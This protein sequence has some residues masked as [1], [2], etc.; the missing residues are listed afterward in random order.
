MPNKITPDLAIVTGGCD[1]TVIENLLTGCPYL[2]TLEMIPLRSEPVAQALHRPVGALQ[3]LRVGPISWV[4]VAA[5]GAVARSAARAALI[6]CLDE[7]A[8]IAARLGEQVAASQEQQAQANAAAICRWRLL[9]LRGRLE[10]LD[11]GGEEKHVQ[12]KIARQLQDAS[13]SAQTLSGGYRCRNLD[14]ICRGG[15]ALDDRFEALAKLRVTL[16]ATSA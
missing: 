6:D 15:Q 8:G 4:G 13:T 10:Q 7:V 11:L 16:A 5:D 1:R 9:T 2:R 14:R 12:S 3:W